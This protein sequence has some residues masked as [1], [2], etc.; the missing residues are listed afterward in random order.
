MIRRLSLLVATVCMVIATLWPVLGG[1]DVHSYREAVAWFWLGWSVAFGW[2]FADA[3]RRFVPDRTWAHGR[4][5]LVAF[6]LMLLGLD[7]ARIRLGYG[8]GVIPPEASSWAVWAVRL[9]AGWATVVFVA[10]FDRDA[11]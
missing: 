1:F 2:F 5:V 4:T 3:A 8:A 11:E 9:I 10:M 6:A 7:T